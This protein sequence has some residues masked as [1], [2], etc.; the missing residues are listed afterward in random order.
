MKTA[1]LERVAG[2]GRL[3]LGLAAA[4]CAMLCGCSQAP[5]QSRREA[6]A[7]KGAAE[8]APEAYRVKFE[9]SKGEFVVE[10]TR[11]WSPHGADHFYDL[12]RTG[13]YDGNRFFR[14]VRNF[15][16]QFGISGDPSANRLWAQANIP[17][18]P[19]KQNNKKGTITYAQLGPRSR[20]TQVFIN[21]KDNGKVLDKAGFA[22]FG[23]VISGMDVVENF[24]N[25]YGEVPPRGDGP[26]PNQIEIRGNAYLESRFPRLDYVS[27][28]Y[29]IPLP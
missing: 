19:V 13:Y 28:A 9:T 18:D 14:V 29:T 5:E 16:V 1:N 20:A 17:D 11:A 23:K 6:P 12:V 27:K 24:Y 10:V 21:L 15:I 8:R 2:R 4:A 7:K 25:S 3:G 26:D 22:P